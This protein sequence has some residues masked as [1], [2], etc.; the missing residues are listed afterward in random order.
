MTTTASRLRHM[1]ARIIPPNSHA[2]WGH[3]A[4]I[5][6]VGL[7]LGM[8]AACSTIKND[9]IPA[10]L[11]EPKADTES[12][13]R[14]DQ[15]GAT[16]T[17]PRF[18]QGGAVDPPRQAAPPPP[19]D[20]GEIK[21]PV[22]ARTKPVA[23]AL[24][25][26]PM[27]AFINVLYGMELG[28]PVQ[29]D[30]S[31]RSRRELLSLNLTKPRPP[32]EAYRIGAEVLRNY[33]VRVTE[34]GGV[35]RFQST[36]ADNATAAATLISTR[37]LPEVPAGQRTVFVAMPLEV[38]APGVIS[39]QM[40]A[41]FG[42]KSVTFTEMPDLNAIM[43]SGPGDAVRSAMEAITA[44][45]RTALRGMR[46]IR[47]N[48]SYL[49][50]DLLAKELKDV[51]AGQGIGVRTGPGTTGPLTF[52]P[53]G[54]AN[55]L[56]VFG[57]SDTALR[58]AQDWADK[59][60]QP[61]DSGDGGGL[62]LYAAKH[63]TVETLVP[64]LQALVG[65]TSATGT[66]TGTAQT[67]A[68]S[69][70]L[71]NA[72]ATKGAASSAGKQATA[73]TGL[74]GQLA[75]DPVR[76]VIVFEGDAQRWRS[77]Q[78]IL[79]R[80]DQPARQVVIEVTVAEVTLTDEFS[81]GVEWALRNIN[82][83]GMSGP[84]AALAGGSVP[85]GALTW[86]ALSSSGQ[87]KAAVNLFAKD[88]RVTILSTP[89][90]LVKS[91]ETASI[92]V[93]TEVPVVTSQATTDITNN[94]SSSILQSIQYRKTGTL[95]NIE[96]VVHSGKRV[97]LKVSQEVSEASQTD[98][99]NISS[100][101]IFSRKLETSLS[102]SDGQSTLLGG[103]I[104]SNH[105]DAKTKVP[106]LGDI[107]ILGRAFQNRTRSGNR[108][109]L[110]LLITPYVVEDEDQAK[111]ITDAVKA[112][113]DGDGNWPGQPLAPPAGVPATG[114]VEDEGGNGEPAGGSANPASSG[115]PAATGSGGAATGQPRP[116]QQAAAAPSVVSPQAPQSDRTGQ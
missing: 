60:D 45:D 13:E 25:G 54:S 29:V 41:M 80:L 11:R 16:R 94:G 59:L 90:I 56:I 103:L 61:N 55:A 96:A 9:G 69:G 43:L 66:S 64:V 88:S 73:I 4:K 23:V 114:K 8:L 99:S 38:A 42:N 2:M 57:S 32:A 46:S 108:T 87:V 110:L 7:V 77:I 15:A 92:D 67:A 72:A 89:R 49:S 112:R 100:P 31:L 95:L 65:G 40:R 74:G 113:F 10:P 102:L 86:T 76:N 20:E 116:S 36:Q 18:E 68:Q 27:D 52:V 75:V 105:T 48:P 12:S 17:R 106:L 1:A 6:V 24:D 104:S 82:V 22:M 85:S 53:V 115:A 93:G 21:V 81:H 51:L 98:T 91:G 39:A 28:F 70:G 107:P 63:T 79:N 5:V 19:Q 26:V 33:G 35:L 83:G 47:I 50:A 37:S 78:N 34:L 62:F 3:W 71:G 14:L 44:L 58:A 109:E 101:S 30:Q 84:V 97:D 111:A